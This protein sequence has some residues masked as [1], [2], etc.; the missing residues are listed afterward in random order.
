M[1]RSLSLSDQYGQFFNFGAFAF[2]AQG[3]RLTDLGLGV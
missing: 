1:S 3:S 2:L